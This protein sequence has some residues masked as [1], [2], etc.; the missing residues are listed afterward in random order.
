MAKT[1]S[2]NTINEVHPTYKA[3]YIKYFA[4]LTPLW[5]ILCSLSGMRNLI[6][7]LGCLAVASA[8]IPNHGG[9][10]FLDLFQCNVR[11]SLIFRLFRS[12]FRPNY[13]ATS[14]IGAEWTSRT[15]HG[16]SR[17][18][19]TLDR[20]TKRRLNFLPSWPLSFFLALFGLLVLFKIFL[21]FFMSLFVPFWLIFKNHIR[22]S[23]LAG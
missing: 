22:L 11:I 15:S 20:K 12:W 6:L 23:T 13:R 10:S 2:K 14:R 8:I 4:Y 17:S 21:V 9:R 19:P 18:I 16:N 1:L 5:N 3:K 7:F